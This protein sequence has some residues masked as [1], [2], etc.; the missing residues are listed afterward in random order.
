MHTTLERQRTKFFGNTQSLP[1]DKAAWELF[2][3][4]VNSTYEGYEQ[5]HILIEHSLELSSKELNE[6]NEKLKEYSSQLA[7]K[8]G[9][10]EIEKVKDEAVIASIGDG[11]LVT[12]AQ[13]H[14]IVMN[15][16]AEE[17]LGLQL[18]AIKNKTV[19]DSF[20]LYDKEDKE[21]PVE[22]RPMSIVLQ[23]GKKVENVYTHHQQNG[24]VA[25]VHFSAN[26]VIL[27]EKIVGVIAII[28]DVTE[29]KAIDR[30]KTEFISLASHQL[31][32]PLSAVRWFSEMLL[33]GDAG[34]LNDEQQDFTRNIYDSIERMIDLVNSLLNISRIES[35]RIIIDPKPTDLKEMVEGVL[36]ELEQ[37]ILKK[38]LHCVVSVN[39]NLPK[40]NIDPRLIRQVYLN[41]LTN[42]IKYTEKGGDVNVFISRK[43]E[44]IIS[45][46]TDTGLGIPKLQQGRLFEKFFRAD[47]AAQKETVGTGL[48]L[49][50]VRI[51]LESSQG[52]IWFASE[53]GKGTT[54]WFSLPAAGTPAKK[55]EVTLD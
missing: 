21:V 11:V 37:L 27:G 46:I 55:G 1:T 4:A 33:Q 52:K 47:N 40:I 17:I 32:T 29:Q 53:E 7:Q 38:E 24:D 43:G 8:V 54:F 3:Q 41:L 5:D 34:K 45:Q 18:S 35:G 16:G 23:T 28:R 50:L 44:E 19:F 15:K 13:A 6:Q 10:V 49:Y 42:A 30:M 36:K 48:G 26:P 39:E 9:E 51:I 12:D 25:F 22:Q 31:R 2:L 20:Q 14:I